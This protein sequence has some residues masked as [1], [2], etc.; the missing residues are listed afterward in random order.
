M[1]H[2]MA[3]PLQLAEFFRQARQADNHQTSFLSCGNSAFAG[4]L[5][6]LGLQLP[7]ELRGGQ[8]SKL[9]DLVKSGEI[10]DVGGGA[11]DVEIVNVGVDGSY[12]IIKAFVG[13]P[14]HA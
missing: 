2:A 14:K 11:S 12:H 9:L 4:V 13:S 5:G 10:T 3:K 1:F 7:P 6:T 8:S